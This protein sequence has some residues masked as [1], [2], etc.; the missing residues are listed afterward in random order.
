[1]RRLSLNLIAVL[2]IAMLGTGWVID[3]VYV[4]LQASEGGP[5]AELAAYEASGA[6]LSRTLDS[7]DAISNASLDHAVA[8]SR[9]TA[10]IMDGDA[11]ALPNSLDRGFKQGQPVT[12]E[13]EDS[14]SIYYYL[15]NTQKILRITP[16]LLATG[17][18][19]LSVLLTLSFYLVLI[20]VIALWAYPLVARL[21]ELKR[22]TAHFAEGNLD[23]RIDTTGAS[24]IKSIEAAFND[25][26]A[27][28]EQLLAE[29]KLL[30]AAVS[31]NLKTPLARL[32]FG[33]DAMEESSATDTRK[34]EKYLRRISADL[35]EMESLVE[36]LLR[37][38]AMDENRPPLESAAFDLIETTHRLTESLETG[39]VQLHTAFPPENL[40][41]ESDHRYVSM[42]INNF[43]DN[44]V[45]HTTTDILVKIYSPAESKHEVVVEVHDNGPGVP[46]EE[47]E[48]IFKPFQRGSNGQ[49]KPGH[50]MGL[51]IA[52]RMAA[53]LDATLFVGQSEELGGAFFAIRLP[54]SPR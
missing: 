22:A 30:S 44:A 40:V 13:N 52:V 33:F 23:H 18:S 3:W 54:I 41:I 36:T 15:P 27:R 42:I 47:Q 25:M 26:A 20:I 24:Q 16:K 35:T 49:G 31:H 45:L 19:W 38:A 9:L 10:E 53:W 28:I 46:H 1:M 17:T 12:L 11:L 21:R 6:L 48:Q 7:Q 29:N 32:R 43:L 14:V 8:F 4:Q 39:T 50:G 34:R 51:A 2:L 5:V 37:Y